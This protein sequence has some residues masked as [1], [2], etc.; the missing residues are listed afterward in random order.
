MFRAMLRPGQGFQRFTIIERNGGL[1]DNG[2]CLTS[3]LTPKGELIGIISQS[4]PSEQAHWRQLGHSIT[5]KVIQISTEISAK[6]TDIL[7][8]ETSAKKK[9]FF[10][11]QNIRNPAELGRFRVYFTE[12]RSDLQ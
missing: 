5:H 9:R 7:K 12:E 8:L 1:S 6:P 10:L 4:T 3:A 2:R 11:V